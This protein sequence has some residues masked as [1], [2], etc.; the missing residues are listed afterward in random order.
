MAWTF[1]TSGA[2]INKAGANASTSIS[3]ADLDR[4]S[5]Q[6]EGRIIAETRRDWKTY[7]NQITSGAYLILGDCASDLIAMKIINYD[8]S[9]F[10]TTASAQ[11]TL[12]VLYDNSNK[13]LNVLRDFKSNDIKSPVG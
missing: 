10:P 5:D 12:D 2:A 7:I 3:G 6:V 13:C 11:L 1:C 4:W 9:G 8:T